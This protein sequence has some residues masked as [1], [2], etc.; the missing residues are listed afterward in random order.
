MAVKKSEV[1]ERQLVLFAQA[2]KSLEKDIDAKLER[3]YVPGERISIDLDR[4][5]NQVLLQIKNLY[6]A[7]GWTVNIHHGDQRD[8]GTCLVFS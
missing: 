8:P 1:S 2:V 3:D 5:S 4:V 7:A 6:T